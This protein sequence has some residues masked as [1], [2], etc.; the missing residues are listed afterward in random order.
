MEE[1]QQQQHTYS[2][3]HE[4]IHNARMYIARWE[5]EAHARMYIARWEEAHARSTLHVHCMYIARWEEAHARSTLH[6]H[7]MYIARW[8]E[9]RNAPMYIGCTHVH[10]EQV[11]NARK[12]EQKQ[13]NKSGSRQSIR[14]QCTLGAG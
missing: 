12:W 5:E 7:C 8:E 13:V 11:N 9:A 2:T 1:E 14:T 4:S 3:M 6:V 10:W